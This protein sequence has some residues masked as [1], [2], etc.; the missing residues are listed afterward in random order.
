MKKISSV[1]I[2][3]KKTNNPGL[4]KRKKNKKK[5]ILIQRGDMI[6]ST[7]FQEKKKHATLYIVVHTC[8]H[9]FKLNLTEFP[10]MF[11]VYVID[12]SSLA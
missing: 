2:G 10:P 4:V 7:Q 8:W 6:V 5:N 12:V 3:L 1:K 9:L 11:A